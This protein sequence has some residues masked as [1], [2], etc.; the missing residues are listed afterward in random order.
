MCPRPLFGVYLSVVVRLSVC[1][2]CSCLWFCLSCGMLLSVCMSVCHSSAG[3][4]S[5]LRALCSHVLC[6]CSA[7]LPLSLSL[8]LS[9]LVRLLRQLS[10]CCFFL[11]LVAVAPIRMVVGRTISLSSCVCLVLHVCMYW[12]RSDWPFA[13]WSCYVFVYP[14]LASKNHHMIIHT[15]LPTKCNIHVSW[16]IPKAAFAISVFCCTEYRLFLFVPLRDC[17]SFC[18]GLCYVRP[19]IASLPSNLSSYPHLSVVDHVRLAAATASLCVSLTAL[20]SMCAPEGMPST[21]YHI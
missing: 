11:S 15:D 4:P 12:W 6:V 1:S 20:T 7:S 14:F 21:W 9:G 16:H 17:P 19:T 10:V 18:A 5:G 8:F 3:L 13:D 2:V